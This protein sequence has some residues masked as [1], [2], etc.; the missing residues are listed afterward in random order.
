MLRR[1][2]RRRLPLAAAATP[3][4]STID[5]AEYGPGDAPESYNKAALHIER[6]Q[7]IKEEY[8][9][10]VENDTW[11]YVDASALD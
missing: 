3:A 11:E 5:S 4:M 1:S 9:P 6:R 8:S 7:A 10:L 2:M